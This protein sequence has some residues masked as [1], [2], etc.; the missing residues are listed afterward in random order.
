MTNP[1][2]HTL[3]GI[4]DA[5]ELEHDSRD[6]VA[7]D[8]IG[9]ILIS[10]GFAGLTLFGIVVVLM[11]WFAHRAVFRQRDKLKREILVG[12]LSVEL[13]TILS[14]M[15]FGSHLGVFPINVLFYL[16]AS[17]LFTAGRSADL[18]TASALDSPAPAVTRRAGA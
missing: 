5:V 16:L 14:G 17:F 3:F 7:H 9:Q 4:P 18:Q 11:L 1:A 2:F 12:I 10:Y 13:A 6:Y 15:L 8:Q